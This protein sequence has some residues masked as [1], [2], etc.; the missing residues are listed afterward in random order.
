V[1]ERHGLIHNLKDEDMHVD[2]TLRDKRYLAPVSNPLLSEDL[3]ATRES[4]FASPDLWRQIHTNTTDVYLHVV[5]LRTSPS[6]VPKKLVTS[7]DFQSGDAL[8]GYVCLV[9]HDK[10]PHRF[11]HRYLLSD[12]GL[13]N[14]TAIEGEHCKYDTC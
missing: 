5:L 7:R 1:F 12:F 2:L 9:K 4:V 8:T 3:N 13:V 6:Q 14:M 10:V 11:R